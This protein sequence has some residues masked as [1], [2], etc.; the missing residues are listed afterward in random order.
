MSQNSHNFHTCN[1]CESVNHTSCCGFDPNCVCPLSFQLV[2]SQEQ[3]QWL[4]ETYDEGEEKADEV[5][6][7]LNLKAN[8]SF[9]FDLLFKNSY[10][11]HSEQTK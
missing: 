10:E 11:H 1:V 7:I 2:D 6:S 3:E 9:R 4:P 5:I 8:S